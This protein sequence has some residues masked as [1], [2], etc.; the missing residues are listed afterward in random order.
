MTSKTQKTNPKHE[1]N[2]KKIYFQSYIC[3]DTFKIIIKK[4]QVELPYIKYIYC[5]IKT[6]HG[7]G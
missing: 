1:S 3:L 7:L 6:V 4:T 5:L 2:Q